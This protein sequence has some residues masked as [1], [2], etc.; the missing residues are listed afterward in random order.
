MRIQAAIADCMHLKLVQFPACLF[1][2]EFD[3]V[4]AAAAQTDHQQLEGGKSVVI[5]HGRCVIDP[6]RVGRMSPAREL[7]LA[8]KIVN[9]DFQLRMHAA[10]SLFAKSLFLYRPAG[11]DQGDALAGFGADHDAEFTPLRFP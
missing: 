9:A 10:S 1:Q 2:K 8:L 6:D 11:T 5:A 3:R 4:P 7:H